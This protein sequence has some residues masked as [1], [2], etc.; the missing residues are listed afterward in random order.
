VNVAGGPVTYRAGSVR[1]E[2]L[3][4][5]P[6]DR[7]GRIDL[8]RIADALGPCDVLDSADGAGWSYTVPHDGATL[9]DDGTST[10]LHDPRT[11]RRALGRDPFTALEAVCGS[12]GIQPDVPLGDGRD[13]DAPAFTG[14]WVGAFSYDLARRVE[15]LPTLARRGPSVLHLH[16]RLADLA[17]AVSAD[18]DE[19]VLVGRDLSGRGGLGER[20]ATIAARL[21]AASGPPPPREGAPQLV[22]QPVRTSLPRDAYLAAVEAVLDRIAAG[23]AF[24]VNL[25]QRLTARWEG[26]ATTFYRRLRAHSPAPFGAL[27]PTIGVASVSPETFLAVDGDAVTTRPIKGTRPRVEDPALDAALADDL[28]TAAKDRAENIMVVDLER[29]DLGRVCVPGSVTVPQL[30]SVERHP[31]VWHLVST[32]TGRLRPGTGYG[33]LLRATFP[34][35]SITGAPKVSAMTIIERLEPVRRAW[36][37]G[38]VGFLSPGAARLSVAIRTATLHGDGTVGFGAG[39][40]IVADSD[41]IAEHAESLDK[42]AAFLRTVGASTL[43]PEGDHP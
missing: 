17:V 7:D 12:L 15:R 20:A 14:G 13:V 31:T 42:A 40:G 39:G 10:V 24:Q 11:G 22:P 25:A 9:V 34:C 32:V 6:R 37:C 26:D 35:G 18:R 1:Y 23:D 19:A 21:R 8:D 30:T 29:N 16:L 33:E 28:A 43:V 27:L 5:V 3:P 38:A 41:P 36:Y 4:A 2:G